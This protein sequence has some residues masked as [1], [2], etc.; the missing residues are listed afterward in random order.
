VGSNPKPLFGNVSWDEVET[1]NQFLC[2]SKGYQIGRTSDGYEPARAAWED[3]RGKVLT[4]E[5][6][7]KL[8]RL[9][10]RQAPFLFLNGNTFVAIARDAI[11]S[12]ISQLTYTQQAVAR[13]A[14]GH[15]IAGTIGEDD[16]K[17][18]LRPIGPP[19]NS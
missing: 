14:V 5:D 1:L 18:A 17:N 12:Q 9:C 2:G 15:F 6:A 4:I 16:L 19:D 3:G 13:G 10:H 11:I 8:C 7:A